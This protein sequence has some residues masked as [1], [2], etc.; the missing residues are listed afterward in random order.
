MVTTKNNLRSVART[1]LWNKSAVPIENDPE[2][3]AS[4]QQRN[5][6][7]VNKG[8]RVMAVR[9]VVVQA[10]EGQ[11]VADGYGRA[12]DPYRQEAGRVASAV[13]SAFGGGRVSFAIETG[14]SIA[15]AASGLHIDGQLQASIEHQEEITFG[16]SFHGYDGVGESLSTAQ[17]SWV[18]VG[19]G[20]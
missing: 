11:M 16:K 4:I 10:E 15:D 12:Q 5:E 6:V 9:D 18:A 3:N 14:S 13:S 17:W 20:K 19:S 7:R 2:A 8:A 1:R